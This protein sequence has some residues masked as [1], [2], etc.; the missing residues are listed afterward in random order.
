MTITNH[1]TG[2][3]CTLHFRPRG[4]FGSKAHVVNGEIVDAAGTKHYTLSGCWNDSLWCWADNQPLGTS[5][6]RPNTATC[7][8]KINPFPP[9]CQQYYHMTRMAMQLNAPPTDPK[10]L[11]PTDSRLRPDQRALECGDV[12]RAADEK[13]RLEEKQREARRQRAETG[14]EWN[15]LWFKEEHDPLTDTTGW[16]FK[17][18]YW[19]KR[20]EAT[21]TGWPD[22]F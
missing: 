16:V 12:D 18:D 14:Q 20:A 9:G 15:P 5:A 13:N 11:V 2:D 4:W 7:L 3:K 21:F 17:G 6:Q 22:I 8:W 19:K 10:A 1:T